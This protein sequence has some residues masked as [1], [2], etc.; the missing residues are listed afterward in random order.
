[1][2]VF[3]EYDIGGSIRSVALPTTIRTEDD[4]T[5]NLRLLPSPKHFIAEVEVA[6]VESRIAGDIGQLDKDDEQLA[7]LK[8]IK[9][10]YLVKGHPDDP[11]LEAKSKDYQKR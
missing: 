3:V 10:E 8:N 11:H 1:M 6:Q 9:Y 4:L 7:A 5:I 2:K